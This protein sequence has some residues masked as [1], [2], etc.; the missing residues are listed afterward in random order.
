VRRLWLV[1]R[2]SDVP[3]LFAQNCAEGVVPK[4]ARDPKFAG[5]HNVQ[6]FFLVNVSKS[7]ST[8]VKDNSQMNVK[9]ITNTSSSAPEQKIEKINLARDQPGIVRLR[10][11]KTAAL[12]CRAKSN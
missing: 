4:Q 11:D 10:V 7:E 1:L 12:Q 9:S 3:L 8:T 6:M 2:L 5:R